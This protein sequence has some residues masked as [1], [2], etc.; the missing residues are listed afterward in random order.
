[1]IERTQTLV[2]VS[3]AALLVVACAPD[4][5]AAQTASADAAPASADSP[6]DASAE[7]TAGPVPPQPGQRY[8]AARGE[9]LA[10]GYEP[11]VS[12]DA[13]P[14]SVCVAE[15]EAGVSLAGDCP[16]EIM[17]LPEVDGCAGTGM[18]NCRTSWSHPGTGRR[19]IVFTTGEPQPGVVSDTA[20]VEAS[21]EPAVSMERAC[22]Q[23]VQVQ[24]GQEGQ[25]VTFIG[26]VVSWRAPV[27]G[28]R[29]S[30]TCTVNGDA[31]SL[32]REGETLVVTLNAPSDRSAQQEAR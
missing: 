14:F 2:I 26:G 22:R 6:S 27:D 32:A 21:V 19:L 7:P 10:Q 9:L 3:A 13:E 28:G 16:G 5:G 4:G 11:V 24:F 29:L 17:V 30:F 18:G 12:P 31:V 25:A 1:L 15:M 8:W 23:A 20:W